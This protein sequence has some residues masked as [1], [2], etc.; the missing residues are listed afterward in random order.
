MYKIAAF[1]LFAAIALAVPQ[2][3]QAAPVGT[4][5]GTTITNTATVNFTILGVAQIAATGST[6]FVVDRKVNLLVAKISDISTSPSF[7]I[8]TL[9]YIVTNNSNTTIRFGMSTSLGAGT[10]TPTS[11]LIWKDNGSTSGVYDGGNTQVTDASILGD[12]ASGVSI[13]V[14][15]TASTPSTATTGQTAAINLIAQAYEPS[16]YGSLAVIAQTGNGVAWTP[17]T[18]QTVWADGAGS[19]AGDVVYDGRHSAFATYTVSAAAIAVTKTVS[20]YADGL[21]VLAPNAKAIPGATVEYTVVI[22]N[23]VGSATASSVTLTDNLPANMNMLKPFSST[24]AVAA[25]NCALVALNNDGGGFTCA[26]SNDGTTWSV[27]IPSLASGATATVV[28]QATIQ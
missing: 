28:Y 18:V 12:I 15:V 14:L 8:S 27:T 5:S 17:G 26:G 2:F 11:V 13:T 24:N 20:V 7:T 10:Y 16:S 1:L 6:S 4:A 9:A 19:A 23:A 3:A 22:K 21:G 25:G